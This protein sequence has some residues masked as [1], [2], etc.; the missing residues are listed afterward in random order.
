MSVSIGHE[1]GFFAGRN[2][3]L[4]VFVTSSREQ[5]PVFGNIV[6]KNRI[7]YPDGDAAFVDDDPDALY[8]RVKAWLQALTTTVDR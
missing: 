2:R 8:C 4:K 1:I 3:P 6:G 7:T 5:H